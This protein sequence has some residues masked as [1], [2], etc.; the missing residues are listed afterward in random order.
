MEVVEPGT[1][2]VIKEIR[3]KDGY[4]LDDTPQTVQVKEGQTVTVEF[5]NQPM[6]NLIIHKLSSKDKTPLEGVQFKI[7][8]ADGSYLPDEGGKLSSNGLYWSNLEGQIILS[9]ITGT[10]VVTEVQSV[11]GYTIDEGT[12][13]QT[14][15]VNP[16]DTQHLYF[17]QRPGKKRWFSRRTSTTVIK[18]TSH[19]PGWN[20]W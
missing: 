6:G 13:S 9:G 14:V 3:A 10:V 15:V 16:D 4:L 19:W 7:T 20:F 18:T 5:R 8:Y 11:P 2:L 1:T 17:L 12:R